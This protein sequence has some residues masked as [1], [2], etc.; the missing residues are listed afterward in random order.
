MSGETATMA[1]RVS[2]IVR[3]MDRPTLSRA[4]ASIALQNHPDI[5]VI[6]VAACGAGHG[7]LDP[8]AHPFALRLVRS[9]APLARAAAA[10]TGLAACRGQR[11]IF[12]DD[13]DEW[14]PGHLA[15][16]EG[17]LGAASERSAAYCRF[18]VYERQMQMLHSKVMVVDDEW[19]VVGSCNLDARSL[20]I[21][22]EFL[23]VV[24]S[25]TFAAALNDIIEAEIRHSRQITPADLSSRPWW[26]RLLDRLAWALRW[27]L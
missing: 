8:S 13:D 1:P 5:E 22:L 26:Q 19:A 16:L 6:V 3:S 7:E 21:N 24:H 18:E 20:Y 11:I 4:L 9:E 2:V 17:A 25:R 27:W 12:L 10:N 15:A 14:L 23:A